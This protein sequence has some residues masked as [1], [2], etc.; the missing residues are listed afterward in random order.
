M[1]R[2]DTI[3]TILAA[4]KKSNWEV[5][6]LDVKSAIMHGELKEYVYVNQHEG[7]I[8]KGEEHKVYKLKKALYGL[9]QAPQAWYSR[10][11]AYFVK[12]N[13]ARCSTQHTLFTKSKG[14]KFII[15]SLYVDDL[16]F[17]G[18]DRG[19]YDEFKSSMMREFKMSDL[20][21]MKYF[22]GVEVKQC[23]E[24]IFS[25]KRNMQMRFWCILLWRKT[26]L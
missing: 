25:V 22:L 15:V 6:Q 1:A 23:E 26:T 5:F 14:G 19:L 3:R 10:I 11:E 2:L 12:E 13:F 20:E 4:A 16:I 17:T 9:K 7:F 18:N 24:G 8:A 21:K